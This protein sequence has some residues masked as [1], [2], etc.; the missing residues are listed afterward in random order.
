MRLFLSFLALGVGF[1]GG[2]SLAQTAAER[3]AC[4]PDYEKYCTGVAPGGGRIIAC[5]AKQLDK[6]S[7]ECRKVV[8]T[9]AP[10]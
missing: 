6:L 5:L 10:K 7:P 4:M 3:Q 1:S 2:T 9:H 8:E